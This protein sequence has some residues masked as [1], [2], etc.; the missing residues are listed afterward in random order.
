MPH[1]RWVDAQDRDA[2]ASVLQD[3][4]LGVMHA[5]GVALSPSD[6]SVLEHKNADLIQK[7]YGPQSF[8]FSHRIPLDNAKAPDETGGKR[9]G[10][11][12]ALQKKRVL[13]IENNMYIFIN[14]LEEN[15]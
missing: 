9:R 15:L 3:S 8:P 7:G 1:D 13:V 11:R 14:G 4:I 6:V 2:R 10:A 12:N 5:R